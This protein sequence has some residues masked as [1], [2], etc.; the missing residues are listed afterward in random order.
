MIRSQGY[1]RTLPVL[2]VA[3]LTTLLIAGAG[4]AAETPTSSAPAS[5]TV[6]VTVTAHR[7]ELEK[8][9]SQFVYQIAASEN[10]GEGVARWETP[11]ACP[12]VSGLPRQDGEFILERLSEIAIGAGIP[13]AEENCRPNLYILVT[14]QPEALLRGMEKRNRAFTFGYNFSLRAET[15]ASVVDEFIKT[16]RPVRVWYNSA[17]KDAWGLALSYCP[18]ADLV[19]IEC[20]MA[21]AYTSAAPGMMGTPRSL[22]SECLH[23]HF[24][25]GQVYQ[26]GRAATG[27]T[28]VSFNN[29]WWLSRVFIIVDQKRL[30]EVKLRQLADYVA[31]A[32]LAK[33]KPDIH[34]GDAPTILA[35]FNG[36]PQT[37]P[38]GI[39]DWD[40]AFLKSLYATEQKSKVQR[41]QIAHQMVREIAPR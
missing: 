4:A 20:Q 39:T 29:L 31:M 18:A 26:C 3:T 9:V 8:R 10:G 36:A 11:H 14:D 19:A 12:L 21:S 25:P 40:K 1:S 2:A 22:Q 7:L 5:R 16:P 13:L 17:E 37:A 35:L 33:L 23:P 32:G 41:S 28:R 27:G 6:E 24:D 34:L 38:A 30:H 15:P